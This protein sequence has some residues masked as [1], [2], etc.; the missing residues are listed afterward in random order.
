MTSIRA[1]LVASV[2]AMLVLT[3]TV[4]TTVVAVR[5]DR[6][7]QRQAADSTSMLAAQHA[8]R[9][10]QQ[11]TGALRSA[12]DLATSLTTL[13]AGGAATRPAATALVR[14]ALEA[15]P[16]FIGVSTA[17]EPQAFDGEDARFAGTA[18]TDASGRFI[19]YWSRSGDEVELSALVDYDDESVADWYFTPKETLQP[20]LTEPYVYPVSGVDVLMT[21]ATAPILSGGRF[22]GVVTVDLGLTALSGS[23]ADIRPHGTGYASLVTDRG[24]VVTHPRADLLGTTLGGALGTAALDASR[25]GEQVTDRLEAD[26][27]IDGPALAA[28][29]P[30]AVTGQQTW[31]LLVSAPEDA[32]LAASHALR[33]STVLLGLGALGAAGA[34]TWVIGTRLTRPIVRLRDSLADIADGDGDL[35]LRVDAER[36]DELGALG[37]A[38][39]RFTETIARTVR[40]IG[41]EAD[42]LHTAAARL[43]GASRQVRTSVHD[44]AQRSG[45][46]ADQA[47]R[48]SSE[49]HGIAAATEQMGASISEI[50]RGTS[51]ATRIAAEAVAVSR[52]TERVVSEL[53]ASSAE[54]GEIVRAITSIAQQTNLLALNATIEAA[55]A[56][57]AG[58]GFAVVAGEVKELSVQTARATEDIERRIAGLQSDV[59]QAAASIGHI[60]AVVDRLDEIQSTVAAAVEEQDA[61]TRELSGGVARAATATEDIAGTIGEVARIADGTNASAEQTDASA[62][63]VADAAERM[64]HL[65]GRFRV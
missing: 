43:D 58:R 14:A 17:W 3:L 15:H 41:T 19:P 53:S 4:V 13:H 26:D 42:G 24:T 60:G 62:R 45:T 48:A 35:T 54:I 28:A 16:E 2:L 32:A 61:T 51:E 25:T 65:V 44:T 59:E 27:V 38:F 8:A 22:L 36:R 5:S 57:E 18:G 1:R 11:L 30:I 9:V 37:G 21:T 29:A 39:N 63:Q 52:S 47:S 46:V 34:A 64:R 7:A 31:S 23:L 50:A 56:G 49:V 20:L 12:T 10:Q 33:D 40:D 6:L 55:R